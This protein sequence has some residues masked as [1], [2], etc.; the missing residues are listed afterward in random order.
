MAVLGQ[1]RQRSFFLIIVIGMAL[2]AFVISGVFDGNNTSSESDPIAVINEEEVDITFFRRMVEQAERSYNFSTTMQAVNSVWQDM[3]RLT[4]FKQEFDKLGIDAGKEQIEMILSRDERITQD[5]RFQNESGFFDFGIF[6]NFVNSLRLE[7]P[8]AYQNWRSQE[9]SIVALAKENIYFDL[10]KSS[11]GFTELEGKDSYHLENDKVNINFVSMPYSEVPDSLFNISDSEI[12]RY[13]SANKEKFKLEAFRAVNYVLFPEIATQ[14]DK[15]EIRNNLENL[16]EKRIE[17]NDVSKLRD[18][19]EGL[20]TTKNITDFIE[21][22]SEVPFDS[23][24]RSKGTLSSEYADILFKLKKGDVFGPYQDGNQFKISKFIDRKIGGSI[25]ASHI[26]VSFKGASRANEE[27]TRSKEQAKQIANKYFREARRNSN[28]FSEL[29]KKYS[30]GPSS[31]M[32]G[33]LGFFQE[34][35]M[36]EKFFSFCKKSRVGRIGLVETEFGFHIIKVTDK[37]DIVLIA[38]VVKQIIPS[39]ETSNDVFQKTTQFEMES[40]NLND[41][42]APAQK[43]K[44]EKKEVNQV[45]LLDENL[46]SME[47]QRNLVQWLFNDDT[48][49][50]DIKRFNLTKGGYVVAQLTGITREG[51][52]NIDAIKEEV[53]QEILTKRKAD[54]LLEKYSNHNSLDKLSVAIKKEIETASAVTQKNNVLPGVG[55]EPYL[56]GVAFALELNQ[57][58][59]LIKGNNGVYKIEVTSKEIAKELESYQ[60]YSNVLKTEEN[61]RISSVIYDA[62]KSAAEIDDNRSVYY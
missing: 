29:A 14:Q 7:N 42:D 5:S 18:T 33:D 27:I 20:K 59:T 3:I 44:Y 47:G 28:D 25:R 16:K 8:Q 40:I 22:H 1:I 11:T 49:I 2:F 48:R 36:T 6:T 31:S 23:I 17:Y 45:N 60:A 10:I 15:N 41:L 32:G 54:Y 57:P 38:D 13:V 62:L 61:L 34:G 24:Y 43:Y 52:I 26:L 51:S 58:S 50:G 21:Q 39:E 37:E 12:K 4:I 53:I 9:E 30:D 46:P 35:T 19:I 55:S 56:I